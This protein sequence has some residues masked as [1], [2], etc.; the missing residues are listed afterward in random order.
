[1]YF[2]R[3]LNFIHVINVVTDKDSDKGCVRVM[4]GGGKRGDSL[5]RKGIHHL[6]FIRDISGV[7]RMRCRESSAKKRKKV[8]IMII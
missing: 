6:N 1:M 2:K 7:Y 4:G 3:C 5:F 8:L